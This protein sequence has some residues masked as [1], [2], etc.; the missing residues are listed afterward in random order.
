MFRNVHVTA[1]VGK[2]SEGLGAS[3]DINESVGVAVT[4]DRQELSNHRRVI[5]TASV[6]FVVVVEAGANGP[7]LLEDGLH[8]VLKKD[9]V[10]TLE[11]HA[12]SQFFRRTE[13]VVIDQLGLPAVHKLGNG[14]LLEVAAQEVLLNLTSSGVEEGIEF[15]ESAESELQHG[16][17]QDGGDVGGLR[18]DISVRVAVV[19]SLGVIGVVQSHV[20]VFSRR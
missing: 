11:E 5:S 1:S 20:L 7:R 17:S 14:V 16:V 12:I 15:W 13:L 19:N 10:T 18:V 4:I 3:E 9:S 8:L 2:S 6:N